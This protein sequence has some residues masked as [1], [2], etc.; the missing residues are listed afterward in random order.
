MIRLL[1]AL[2]LSTTVPA[3]A[4]DAPHL[5]KRGITGEV[6]FT[7][8][9]PELEALRH[10]DLA[11][12]MLLRLER[13]DPSTYVA[14]F[15][16]TVEGDYDL[17]SLIR[18]RDGTPPADLDP[19]QVRVVSNLPDSFATDLYDAADIAYTTRMLLFGAL[20]IAVPGVVLVRRLTRP[21]VVEEAPVESPAP[22]FADQLRPLVE[23]ASKRELSVEEQGR[24]ELLLYHF[25]RERLAP[26]TSDVADAIG[27]IRRD[28]AAG[29]ILGE[30]ERWLHRPGA[31]DPARLEALLA[32][33]RRA[34]PIDE[35]LLA[36]SEVPA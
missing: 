22:T 4:Q 17:R 30:V 31:H 6:T 19:L 29:E 18:R 27:R 2:L 12:P 23:A 3:F 13:R 16:G 9:G 21:K 26:A 1:F 14:R 28:R 35:R 20:W 10:Q 15:I 8:D 34:D 11:S 33:Y 32:P 7:Y 5:V 25:W 36:G 24:L